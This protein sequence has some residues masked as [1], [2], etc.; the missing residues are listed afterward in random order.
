MVNIDKAVIA[1]LSSHGNTFEVLVDCDNAIKFKE[2]ADIELND[3]LATEQ[4]FYDAKK[5]LLASEQQLNAVFE[6]VDINVIAKKIIKKGEI[7][8]TSEHRAK[9]LEQKKQ[10]ILNAIHVNG[11]DPKTNLPHPMERLKLAFDEAKIRI[12][13][14]R[15]FEEQIEPIIKKLRPILPIRIAQ[16]K[17][18][19]IIPAKYSGKAYSAVSGIGKLLRNDWLNDGSWSGILEIPAGLQAELFDKLNKLTQGEVQTKIIENEH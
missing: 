4:V 5:G 12:D 14:H 1:R 10:K 6:S 9:L 17:I 11:V 19:V 15:S 3:V 13:E 8:I 7:Q 16:L 2:N 18:Q